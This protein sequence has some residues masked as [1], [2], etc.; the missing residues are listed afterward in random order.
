MT[1]VAKETP[2]TPGG[3][4]ED[5]EVKEGENDRREAQ[6]WQVDV[7]REM[8]SLMSRAKNCSQSTI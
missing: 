8:G 4:S 3:S 7:T 2:K 5:W 1:L 6:V